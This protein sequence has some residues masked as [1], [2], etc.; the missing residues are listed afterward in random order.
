[1]QWPEEKRTEKQTMVNNK[2][3]QKTRDWVPLTKL[4]PW[5][6]SDALER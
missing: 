4:K 6:N 5:I 3:T 2:S 1:M